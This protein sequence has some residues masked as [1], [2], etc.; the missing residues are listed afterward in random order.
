M[1]WDSSFGLSWYKHSQKHVLFLS[2]KLLILQC[3]FIS[4]LLNY[5]LM[6]FK[7][8]RIKSDN[9][10]TLATVLLCTAEVVLIVSVWIGGS[11]GVT[12]DWALPLTLQ[13]TGLVE[14]GTNQWPN[15]SWWGVCQKSCHI[16]KNTLGKNKLINSSSTAT[17]IILGT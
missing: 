9:R 6:Q 1:Y 2:G 16:K 3:E 5:R 8:F 17:I 14:A 4:T 15:Y 13:D 12:A 10:N 7:S 11:A